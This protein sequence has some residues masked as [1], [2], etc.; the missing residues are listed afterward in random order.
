MSFECITLFDSDSDEAQPPS[1]VP[2][3]GP[4]QAGLSRHLPQMVRCNLCVEPGLLPV[5]TDRARHR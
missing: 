2:A 4:P 5:E 1:G 3:S